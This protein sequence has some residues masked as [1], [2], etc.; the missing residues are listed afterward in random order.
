MLTYSLFFNNRVDCS[1]LDSMVFALASPLVG[2]VVSPLRFRTVC[3]PSFIYH[4]SFGGWR[5]ILFTVT[6][7][8]KNDRVSSTI[9]RA[10]NQANLV[11]A[12]T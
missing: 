5:L 10:Q 2:L 12:K 9:E 4:L 3:T 7:A 1:I 6:M 8:T 11:L